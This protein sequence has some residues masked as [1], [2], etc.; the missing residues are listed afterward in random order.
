MLARPETRGVAGTPDAELGACRRGRL[1]AVR[2]HAEIPARGGP[3]A[4]H[5]L[6][7]MPGHENHLARRLVEAVNAQRGDDGHRPAAAQPHALAPPRAV[8]EARRGDEV[9]PLAESVL[10]LRHDDDEAPG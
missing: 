5:R 10:L 8:P 3:D 4:R 1:V 9:H 6:A 7:R 2:G